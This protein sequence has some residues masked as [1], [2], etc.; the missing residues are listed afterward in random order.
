MLKI[1]CQIVPFLTVS[2]NVFFET[3]MQFE[4]VKNWVKSLNWLSYF[5]NK[6]YRHNFEKFVHFLCCF[7]K[8]YFLNYGRI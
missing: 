1:I 4:T 3:M 6:I 2:K 5:Q 8:D 7:Q